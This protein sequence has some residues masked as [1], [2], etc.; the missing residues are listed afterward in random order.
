MSFRYFEYDLPFFSSL[1]SSDWSWYLLIKILL[2]WISASPYTQI[3]EG[4]CSQQFI[5]LVAEIS[6]RNISAAFMFQGHFSLWSQLLQVFTQ[7]IFIS[8]ISSSCSSRTL[9]S[10][11]NL[12][13]WH[14]KEKSLI[15]KCCLGMDVKIFHISSFL[16]SFLPIFIKST[17]LC[18]KNRT[19][20]GT[21]ITDCNK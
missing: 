1:L 16:H 7:K 8:L 20:I 15:K 6:L 19:N 5:F 14:L 4:R 17:F 9:S 10:A 3:W 21:S 13:K 12:A 2:F 11:C 18:F